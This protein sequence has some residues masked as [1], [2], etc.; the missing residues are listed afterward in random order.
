MVSAVT[1]GKF[2]PE[3]DFISDAIALLVERDCEEFD[4]SLPGAFFHGEWIPRYTHRAEIFKYSKLKRM[5]GV[6][7]LQ[8]LGI[9]EQL[10]RPSVYQLEN[11]REMIQLYERRSLWVRVWNAWLA[12]EMGVSRHEKKT[13]IERLLKIKVPEID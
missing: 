11:V 4:R 10:P 13:K 6:I 8:M 3:K 7:A 1:Y 9:E 12:A 2:I 5:Q